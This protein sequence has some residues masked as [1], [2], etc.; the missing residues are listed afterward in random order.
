LQSRLLNRYDRT[1]ITVN[2]NMG[3]ATHGQSVSE[4]MGSGFAATP[5]QCFT[6]KQS[7]LTF[8]QAITQTG[9]PEHAAGARQCDGVDRSS[10]PL[11][12]GARPNRSSQP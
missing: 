12:P 2:A 6:L 1:V 9:T 7:P 10:G 5:N 8:I 11:Q 4:V 3:L